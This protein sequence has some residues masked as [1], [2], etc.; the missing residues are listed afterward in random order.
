MTDHSQ[1]PTI[2]ALMLGPDNTITQTNLPLSLFEYNQL[3]TIMD[4]IYNCKY[5]KKKIFSGTKNGEYYTIFYQSVLEDSHLTVNM[6][7][8]PFIQK[9]YSKRSLTN[10]SCY[11]ACYIL[12]YNSANSPI[13]ID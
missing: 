2:R 12:K 4:K 1:P 8:L 11:G 13:D 6:L 9:Y 3:E 5:C 7:A 10:V